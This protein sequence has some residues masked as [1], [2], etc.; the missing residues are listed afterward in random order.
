MYYE[1]IKNFYPKEMGTKKGWCLQN[2]RL[3]FR[4]Y[5]GKYASAKSAYE[6]AKRNGTLRPMEEL[7]YDSSVPVYQS[8]TSKYGHVI[9]YH[10]G[11]YYSDGKVVKDPKGLLGFDTHMDGVQVV[12]Q[13]A[14][15][16]FLP[17]KGYWGPNDCDYR[18]GQLASFMRQKFPAY[19]SAKA[20]GDFYGKYLT[21]SIMEFQ[22]RTSLYP[23]GCTGP[24]TYD[25]LKKYGFI[26]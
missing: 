5:T 7:T 4:I 26:Y 17:A 6:A 11:T 15:K 21:K 12:R 23:D 13:T 16:K 10:M 9:V 22:R 8:S 18:V 24:K 25:M 20:L 1:N 2:C 3:G 14:A 19:T